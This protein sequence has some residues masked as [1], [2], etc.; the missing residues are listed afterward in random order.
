MLGGGGGGGGRRESLCMHNIE[1]TLNALH[2]HSP[3]STC[4]LFVQ[5]QMYAFAKPYVCHSLTSDIM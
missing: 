3:I 2:M 5:C 1:F 4:A